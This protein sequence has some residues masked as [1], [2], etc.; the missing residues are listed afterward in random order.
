M[1]GGPGACPIQHDW[2][3]GRWEAGAAVMHGPAAPTSAGHGHIYTGI[4]VL[5]NVRMHGAARGSA[6]AGALP[7]WWRRRRPP[8]GA[9]HRRAD[10]SALEWS[11][12]RSPSHR[13][14][15]TSLQRNGRVYAST[16]FSRSS[17]VSD[18]DLRSRPPASQPA[19]PSGVVHQRRRRPPTECAGRAGT[20]FVWVGDDSRTMPNLS[21]SSSNKYVR[22]LPARLRT[23]I[24]LAGRSNY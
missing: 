1:G 24:H 14:N 3:R 23:C 20:V 18:A 4:Y 2:L 21:A 16:C 13:S 15:Y 10:T 5:K 22:M 17:L 12:S 11:L 19:A 8:R 6:R 9:T 7:A